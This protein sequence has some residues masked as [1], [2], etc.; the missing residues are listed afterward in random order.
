MEWAQITDKNEKVKGTEHI[1]RDKTDKTILKKA[2]WK[3]YKLHITV[4]LL[5]IISE[6]IG[7]VEFNLTKDICVVIMPLLYAMVLGLALFLLNQLNG[8]LKN[9]LKL[10]K[11]QCCY[12]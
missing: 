7:P 11:V 10:Q 9:N 4:L 5:V 8:L 3:D 1:Y 6:F 2:P 12:L